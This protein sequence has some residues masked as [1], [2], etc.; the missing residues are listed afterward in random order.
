[1]ARSV[2]K[3]FRPEVLKQK[4]YRLD[5]HAG[6]I[7]LDQNE[8][9][10]DFSP[11][12]KRSWFRALKK[13]PLQ[14]YPTVRPARLRGALAREL[15][16]KPSQILLSPGSNLM[17]TTLVMAT[18][19]GGTV[20]ALDPSFGLYPLAAQGLGNRFIPLPL[21]EKKFSL[22]L[23]GA[24]KSIARYRP[25]IIFIANPN[26]PTGNLLPGKVLEKIIRKAPGLVVLDEAYHH[27]SGISYL[28]KLR[29]FP[30]LV[31]LQTFSKSWGL[32]GARIGY[33]IAR[34]EII[35][36][37]EKMLNPYCINPLSEA[38]ALTALKNKKYF[39]KHIREVIRERERVFTA[40]S[41][42][43]SVTA[44]PSE[45]NFILFKVD[46]AKRCF[47]HL[48]KKKILVRDMSSHPK[49]NGCLRV[50]IGRP[51][52]NDAFLRAIKSYR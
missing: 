17:I 42:I 13:I 32:G 24:L 2:K 50:T 20:M 5:S 10:Y 18:A 21:D 19:V 36:E 26:A 6:V 11:A 41:S 22:D 23:G 40:L 48:L 37:V 43:P 9:G 8:L 44:F 7:K 51:S 15:R 38:A 45:A 34:P 30:N 1:M 3:F 33:L 49:L 28:P 14:R 35:A 16:V 25:Q 12:M 31:I 52:E 39:Q 29:R 46:D 4:A 27:F 47:N